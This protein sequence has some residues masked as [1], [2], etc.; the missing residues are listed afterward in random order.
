MAVG[1]ADPHLPDLGAGLLDLDSP[2][3]KLIKDLAVVVDLEGQMI[4]ERC[5]RARGL[6]PI[7]P[8]GCLDQ[9]DLGGP[10]LLPDT[11][12]SE[13]RALDRL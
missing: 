12:Q 8:F 7:D 10:R 13:V 6:A 4:V 9:V 2:G 1:I 3:M 5:E 11:G